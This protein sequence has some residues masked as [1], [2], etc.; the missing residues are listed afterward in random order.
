MNQDTKK[1]IKIY[2]HGKGF[3]LYLRIKNLK[4]AVL[5]DQANRVVNRVSIGARRKFA[6][7][8]VQVCDILHCVSNR[9]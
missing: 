5:D 7:D 1:Y 2:P 3:R 6:Q 4:F 9:L 8:C